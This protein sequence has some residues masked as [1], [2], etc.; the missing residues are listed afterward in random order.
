MIG[1]RAF[2]IRDMVAAPGV[3]SNVRAEGSG[4]R[5]IYESLRE[6]GLFIAFADRPVR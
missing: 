1:T 6:A 3:A 2:L 4:K 5:S